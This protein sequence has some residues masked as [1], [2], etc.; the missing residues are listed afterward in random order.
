[1]SSRYPLDE[2]RA[3]YDLVEIISPYVALKRTGK[4]LKGL[5]PF[6]AEKTPSFI[7]N[8]DTQR[9]ICFGCGASGDLFDFLMR[10]EGL[11]FPETVEQ[12][13]AKA[14][15][16]IARTAKDARSA[17]ERDVLLRIN[18]LATV[19]FRKLLERSGEAGEYVRGREIAP[20]IAEQFKI[21]YAGPEWDGLALY[22]KGQG[23]KL[24]DA[25]KAGLVIPRQQGQGYYDR[26]RHRLIFPIFD[27]QNR[28]IGFGGRALGESDVKYI[29]TPETRLFVKNRTLYSLNF[30]RKAIIDQGSVVLVEGYMDALTA[31]AAGFVN[32]V[33]TM[34]TALTA[35]HVNVL[36]RYTKSAVLAFDAD[37]A[38]MAAALRSASMFEAADFDVRAAPMPAGEDPDSLIRKGNRAVFAELVAGAEPIPDYR[39]RMIA[40]KHDTATREGRLAMLKEAIPIVAEVSRQVEQERLIAL[41]APY[42]PNYRSGTVPAELHIRQEI[43]ARRARTGQQ[44]QQAVQKKPEKIDLLSEEGKAVRKAERELLGNILCSGLPASDVLERLGPGDFVSEEARAIAA[45]LHDELACTGTLSIEALAARLKGTSGERL[46][47]ELLVT[48]E[49]PQDTPIEDLVNTIKTYHKKEQEKRFRTLAQKIQRGEIKRTDNEFAEYWQLV[50]ELHE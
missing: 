49:D 11:T 27:V 39:L 40:S 33:A 3:R 48:A 5:C 44:R 20:E 19:Y 31:H 26:F 47:N 8:R 9:W 21:G 29:N 14:G 24:E 1:M 10:I 17:G 35:E 37:S 13:A 15:I 50:R 2:I 46:L 28:V 43:E 34:G 7:V 42:H 22:L 30:A 6:H 4:N 12:L 18:N 38:G 23:V 41:L 25:A 45:A 16:S 32:V 36:S